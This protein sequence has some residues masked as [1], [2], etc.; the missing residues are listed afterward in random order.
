MPSLG[1][2][3]VPTDKRARQKAGQRARR[4]AELAEAKRRQRRQRLILGVVVAA[5]VL[6][7]LTIVSLAGGDDEKDEAASP[8][9]TTTMPKPKVTVPDEPAPTEL[10]KKDLKVGKGPAAKA[11]DT[12]DVNYVGVSY[13]DG[14]E[15]DASWNRGQTFSFTIGQGDV[16]KG[17]DEGVPGMKVG[18]RRQLTIPGSLAYGDEDT[19]DGRPHG[20]LIFVVD[21]V[22]IK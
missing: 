21:L 4:E 19:G 11:G 2:L 6:G 16:I 1:L 3:A 14:T 10:E 5:I 13:A 22:A 17:W 9:T 12:V 8:T 18:G 15:F 20:T 7:L